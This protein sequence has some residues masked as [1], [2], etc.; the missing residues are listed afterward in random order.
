MFWMK[1]IFE[2]LFIQFSFLF[3][4]EICWTCINK[5]ISLKMKYWRHNV[6]DMHNKNSKQSFFS[7]NRY[8]KKKSCNVYASVDEVKS[9]IYFSFH[10]FAGEYA[11]ARNFIIEKKLSGNVYRYLRGF[12]GKRNRKRIKVACSLR[13]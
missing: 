5:I 11:R 7:K 13:G 12:T 1:E 4:F 3:S 2:I 8:Q 9:N 6:K 10:F